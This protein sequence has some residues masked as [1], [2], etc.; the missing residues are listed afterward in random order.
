MNNQGWWPKYNKGVF[1]MRWLKLTPLLALTVAVV[2][3]VVAFSGVALADV[4][5]YNVTVNMSYW[6]TCCNATV[7]GTL[8]ETDT[9]ANVSVEELTDFPI[10]ASYNGSCNVFFGWGETDPPAGGWP[11]PNVS[12]ISAMDTTMNVSS[13]TT[14]FIF[15]MYIPTPAPLP[16]SIPANYSTVEYSDQMLVGFPYQRQNFVAEDLHWSFYLNSSHGSGA[17]C[18]RTSSDGYN[19]SAQTAIAN[20]SNDYGYWPNYNGSSFSLWYDETYNYVHIAFVNVSD[21]ML[22]DTLIYE[23]AIPLANGS[24]SSATG[25]RQ[26]ESPISTH[27][28]GPSICT[29]STGYPFIGVTGY[30]WGDGGDYVALYHSKVNNGL[31]S[32]HDDF[33]MYDFGNSSAT[34]EQWISVLPVT[35]GNVSVQYSAIYMMDGGYYYMYQNYITHNG[36][37]AWT[38]QGETLISSNY[39]VMSWFMWFVGPYHSEVHVPT[40]YN[41][42]DI[43]MVYTS[44][45]GEFTNLVFDTANENGSWDNGYEDSLSGDSYVAAMSIAN[46]NIDLVLTLNDMRNQGPLYTSP[47]D[48]GTDTWGNISML[49]N[50]SQA[51]SYD[52]WIVAGYKYA[53]PLGFQW[54]YSPDEGTFDLDYGWYGEWDRTPT[55]IVPPGSPVSYLLW[56]IPLLALCGIIF[57]AVMIRPWNL[58]TIIICAI[59]ILIGLAFVGLLVTTIAGT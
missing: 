8:V 42:D 46:S 31:W 10:N 41:D 15:S 44:Y 11:H 59:L 52:D 30:A 50:T 43:F 22:G 23:R 7:N 55:P 45:D 12:N 9:T 51:E 32:E 24:L 17:L 40:I 5:Y 35:D 54:V 34:G 2:A 16:T 26:V 37:D 38:D 27:L 18:Y 33:P 14:L 29:N 58:Y 4:A 48:I 20:Y 57:M 39:P 28:M 6:D 56:M 25:W 3:L 47:Y 36:S 49:F 21:S 53:S 19:W 13:N 1:N